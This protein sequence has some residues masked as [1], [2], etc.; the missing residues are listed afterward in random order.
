MLPFVFFLSILANIHLN[1]EPDTK[2]TMYF[3]LEKDASDMQIKVYKLDVDSNIKYSFTKDDFNNYDSSYEYSD[4]DEYDDLGKE[5]VKKIADKFTYKLILQNYG[6]ESA[7]VNL[8]TQTNNPMGNED[9]D[10][11]AI[12]KLF[13]DIENLLISLYNSNMRLKTMQD[14][15]ILEAKRI[16]RGLYMLFL[17]PIIYFAVGFIKVRAT[18]NMFAPKKGIKP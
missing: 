13:S 6:S 14:K 7:S 2:R 3:T 8:H 4:E 10:V 11:K 18:V 17:L 16:I 1:L 5:F 15:S 9:A 12:R